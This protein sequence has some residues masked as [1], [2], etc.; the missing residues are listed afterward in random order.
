MVGRWLIRT[1]VV[2]IAV[3]LAAA[4]AR[5][6]ADRLE[7]DRGPSRLSRGLRFA[8]DRGSRIL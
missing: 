6:V 8:A 4:G 3:P 1:A 7:R 5:R 2:M